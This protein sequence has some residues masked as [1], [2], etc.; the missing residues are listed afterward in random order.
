M[1]RSRWL[2][3]RAPSRSLGQPGM[4]GMHFLKITQA[5]GDEL[6]ARYYQA[7]FA[8]RLRRESRAFIQL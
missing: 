4:S 2:S 1:L 3:V 8:F 5:V 7:Q 6:L